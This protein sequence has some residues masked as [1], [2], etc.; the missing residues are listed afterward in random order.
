[1]KINEKEIQKRIKFTPHVNQLAIVDSDARD[2]VIN[3]GRR[4]GKSATCAYI[5]LRVLLQKDKKIWI[6]APTY[7]LSKRVFD[8]LARW[9]MLLAPE[10]RRNA[11]AAGISNRPIPQIR[12]PWGTL[13]QCKSAEN[14]AGLL[15]EEL[16]LLIIDECSRVKRDVYESYLY[17]TTTVRKAKTLFISTPFGKNWFYEK[18]VKAK[19]ADDGAAFQFS[20]RD[21][22]T[23]P[24]VEAEWERAKKML[25][26]MTFDQEYRAVFLS[27]AAS[28]FRGVHEI[29]DPHCLSEPKASHQYV[30]GVD[31]AK[32][33]DFTV[34]TVMDK[35]VMPHPVVY[36]DRFNQIDWNL[37]KARITNVAKRYNNARIVLDSTS[38]GSPISDDLKRAGCNIQDFTFTRKSKPELVEKLTINIE[39]RKIVIPSNEELIDELQAY[40]YKMTE[41][42]NVTYSAPT[43]LHDDMVMSLAL[44]VWSL[45][46]RKVQPARAFGFSHTNY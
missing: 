16:D 28:V 20:T 24:D 40:G 39:Q 43:G 23:I 31:L 2:I 42:G 9:Y 6:V 27:D 34:L 4:F 41:S 3:A 21:N 7:E 10:S 36:I 26:A 18:W 14:P 45:K 38:V 11:W 8:Y 22:P 17:P 29:V 15:G 1:M 44:A 35:S 30:V 13:V 33:D 25:P 5:A 46:G 37:Q 12:T 32:H 19:A